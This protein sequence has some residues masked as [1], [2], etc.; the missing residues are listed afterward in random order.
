MIGE[1]IFDKGRPGRRGSTLP[2]MDVPDHSAVP[3]GLSRTEAAP[4]PEVT[5]LDTVRHYVNLSRKKS[6]EGANLSSP[7]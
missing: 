5:E 2:S 6:P 7:G 3:P 1:L 4:L